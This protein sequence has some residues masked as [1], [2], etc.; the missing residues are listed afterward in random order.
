MAFMPTLMI[1]WIICARDEL[2]QPRGKTEG[3]QAVAIG[4]QMKSADYVHKIGLWPKEELS[5]WASLLTKNAM[6]VATATRQ[7]M[8]P[9]MTLAR[10]VSTDR[11]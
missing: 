11:E 8:I 4:D 3:F 1:P 2:R 9:N 7:E 6:V 10:K 5:T